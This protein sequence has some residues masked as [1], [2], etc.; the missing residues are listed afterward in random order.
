MKTF[1]IILKEYIEKIWKH[2]KNILKQKNV[3]NCSRF[4]IFITKSLKN[5]QHPLHHYLHFLI[6][7]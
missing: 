1:Q 5:S 2:L 6:L 3:K 4:C 7:T